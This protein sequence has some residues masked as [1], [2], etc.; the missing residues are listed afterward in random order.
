MRLLVFL[1]L[2]FACL[3]AAAQQPSFVVYYTKGISGK[4]GTTGALKKGDKL[5]GK[6]VINVNPGA[7]VILICSNYQTVKL[8]AKGKYTVTALSKQ[9]EGNKTS[10]TSNYFN[11]IWDE[12]TATHGGD[13]P[14]HYMKNSGAVSRGCNTV[15][16]KLLLDTV[17]LPVY[18]AGAESGAFPVWFITTF[19]KP[20]LS[21]FSG[22][23]EGDSMWQTP[24]V[25]NQFR[26]DVLTKQ[27]KQPGLYY[28][29]VTGESEKGCEPNVIQIRSEAAYRSA[30]A[31]LLAGLP[32]ASPA[33]TAYMKAFILEENYF[34]GEAFKYYEQAYKLE[35]TNEK[36]KLARAR[37]YE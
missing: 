20:F 6:D 10:F 28:W 23:E 35:P 31:R 27:M 32:V 3:D 2:S 37:F 12:L 26:M 9:C 1:L 30:I 24:L 15:E 18:K 14:S 17:I 22:P 16:T 29:Q 19:E 34:T 8:T 11:Y 4:V 21:R 5:F 13:D 25:K 33:E 36:Y 7:Q